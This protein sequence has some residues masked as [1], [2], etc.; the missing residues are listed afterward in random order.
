[1]PRPRSLLRLT[2]AGLICLAVAMGIGRFAFTPLLPLMREEG[3]VTVAEGGNLAFAHFLGYLIGATLAARLPVSP[4][5]ALAGSLL[6]IAL[7]TLGMGLTGNLALWLAFRWIAGLC[8]AFTLVI[9]SSTIVKRLAEAGSPG[10]QGWVFAGVGAG[11]ML[12]G[13]GTLAMMVASTGSAV[14]WLVFGAIALAGTGAVLA[15]TGETEKTAHP[16]AARPSGAGRMPLT[17]P[18]LI[19]YGAAGM[20]Y[21]IPATYLPVMAREIVH[22]PLVFGWSWPVF[23][24]AAFLSTL[25]ATRLRA[26]PRQVWAACQLVM[27]AGLV[28]PAIAGHIVM[29]MAAGIAVGGTF[30]IITMAGI[31]E[32]HRIAPAADA[33]RHIA[34]MTTAF[35]AGQM[36]G[37]LLAARAYEATGSFAAPLLVA[38]LAL[39]LTALPLFADRATNRSEPLR[40]PT[41][42]REPLR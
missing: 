5:T 22:S 23:G 17:W 30:M 27:A 7:S 29:I 26:A 34:A 39:G 9:V 35:A 16:A 20:G 13:L 4:R 15:M 41:N 8:S 28:L 19:A 21:I 10:L 32:M 36:I 40:R 42:R 2:A 12:A 31:K 38:S 3:L 14:G 24:L 33:P 18:L 11:I 1:M 25:I 6:A 37:P